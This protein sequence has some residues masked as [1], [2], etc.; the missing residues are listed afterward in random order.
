M[1]EEMGKLN[2]PK[3]ESSLIPSSTLLTIM[4]NLQ[5]G[6]RSEFSN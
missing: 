4:N 5:A 2:L 6:K 1:L 3:I